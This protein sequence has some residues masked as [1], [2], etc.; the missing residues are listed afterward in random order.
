MK[1]LLIGNGAREH[2]IAEKLARDCDLYTIMSKKNPAIAQLSREHWICNIEDPE[3]V[4][5]VISG[6]SFDIGFSSPDATLAAGV[7]DVL[8]ATGMAVA[9]PSKAAS[10]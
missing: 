4:K 9:S 3:E 10:R 5:K 1:V 2:A 7:S 6:K 8:A